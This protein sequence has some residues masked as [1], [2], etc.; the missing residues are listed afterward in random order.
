MD[1]SGQSA[2]K[3][4]QGAAINAGLTAVSYAFKRLLVAEESLCVWL[5]ATI[6]TRQTQRSTRVGASRGSAQ[7]ARS[8]QVT[9]DR[10]FWMKWK[11]R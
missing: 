7:A 5:L 2:V 6:A 8:R 10:F 11:R 1:A 4:P 9:P 3:G